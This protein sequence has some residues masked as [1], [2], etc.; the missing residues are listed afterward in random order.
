MRKFILTLM[1]SLLSCSA[2]QA[3]WP[4]ATDSSLEIGV[5]Y[6]QD[7][8]K[9]STNAHLGG[10]G[11]SDYSG[12]SEFSSPL[13]LRSDLKWRNLQ[14][15]QIEAV[16]RYVT[17]DNIYLRANGDYGWITNGKNRDSDF[18][19]FGS[20]SDSEFSR[21][22]SHAKGHVYDA[23]LAVG[24]QWKMCDDSF[25]IAPLIGYSWHGQHI[26]DRHLNFSN[27]YGDND[28]FGP[29]LVD[30]CCNDS[31]S[32]YSN[33]F[34]DDYYFSGSDYYFESYGNSYSNNSYGSFGGTNS[35]YH[36]RWN[37]PFIGFDFDYHFWCDWTLFGGYEF[38]WARYHAKAKWHFRCDLLDGF[39]HRAKNAYGNVFDI[40]L[41]W[42]FCDC[43]TVALKGEFQWW[44]AN[45]GRDRALI[46]ETSCG[47][48][49]AKCFLSIPLRNI[50][51]HSESVSIDLGMVF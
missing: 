27:F 11:Y 33:Y 6:R 5:G 37:G 4:E 51:W 50:K 28:G 3:F 7:T 9:W 21:S 12:F 14:I 17:C 26:K 34:S 43:W 39:H 18:F 44:W 23:K 46:A 13:R 48:V 49:D 47:N 31:Y 15:W 8:V 20:G 32:S 1:A 30:D 41:R 36:T 10:S 24:Y 35:T 40:G 19:G 22:S 29:V 2:A 25:S 45:H 38:H 16:G 42:D